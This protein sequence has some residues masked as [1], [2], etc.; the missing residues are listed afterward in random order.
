MPT[1]PVKTSKTGL[2]GTTFLEVMV[3][4]VVLSLIMFMALPA[5]QSIMASAVEEESNRLASV[6]RMLRNEA[7]LNRRNFRLV[8]NLKEGDYKVEEKQTTG[9]YTERVDPKEL[10][11]HQ[12]PKG[13]QFSDA[14]MLGDEFSPDGVA[15]MPVHIDSSGFIDPFVLHF[16]DRDTPWTFRV[17]GFIGKIELLEGTEDQVETR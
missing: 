15:I 16:T 7:V 2:K 3:V 10:R 14:K 9:N 1:F 17:A 4:M 11:A 6:I 13:F 12:F 5:F 8:L